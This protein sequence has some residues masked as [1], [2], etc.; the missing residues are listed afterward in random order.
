MNVFLRFFHPGVVFP[1]FS[2]W[3][4]GQTTDLKCID[5]TCPS[6]LNAVSVA[7]WVGNSFWAVDPL[8]PNRSRS[9]L[10]LSDGACVRSG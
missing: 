7:L 1:C 8:A 5:V 10:E 4:A 9:D 2:S 6:E 3:T